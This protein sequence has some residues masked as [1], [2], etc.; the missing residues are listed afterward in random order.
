M[1]HPEKSVES[2]LE[3]IECLILRSLLKLILSLSK[4]EATISCFFSRLFTQ[5]A[6]GWFFLICSQA[7]FLAW[8]GSLCRFRSST[9]H[10]PLC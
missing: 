8:S 1:P 10:R 7:K 4:D 3:P 2:H 6:F 9:E 5:L